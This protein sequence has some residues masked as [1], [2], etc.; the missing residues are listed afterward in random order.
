MELNDDQVLRSANLWKKDWKTGEESDTLAAA[1]LL[2]KFEVIQ[3]I[4]PHYKTDAILK[5]DNNDLY[6]DREIVK[7]PH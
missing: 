4:L 6:D 7:K 3:Q 1:L 5:R 2:G